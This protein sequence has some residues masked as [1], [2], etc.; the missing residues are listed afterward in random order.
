MNKSDWPQLK[1]INISMDYLYIQPTVIWDCQDLNNFV[2]VN[3]NF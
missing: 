1:H 3:G 2:E